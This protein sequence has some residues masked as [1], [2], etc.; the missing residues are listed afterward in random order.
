[1]FK[2]SF[3]SQG[4]AEGKSNTDVVYNGTL[5]GNKYLPG[6]GYNRSLE[7]QDIDER[8]KYGLTESDFMQ[9]E[10]RAPDDGNRVS[11]NI[12]VGTEEGQTAI[13][14]GYLHK[15]WRQEGRH[16]F[17]YKTDRPIRNFYSIVSGR[18]LVKREQWHN[19]SLEIYYHPGH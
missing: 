18:F 12:K 1:N 5:I 6:I 8:K 10:G 14:P 19:I 16:Y 7:L 15:E 11:L 2:V 4:F 3:S 13:A 9:D 17:Q